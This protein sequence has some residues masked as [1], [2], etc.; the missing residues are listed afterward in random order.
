MPGGRQKRRK[1]EGFQRARAG[2]RGARVNT[3]RTGRQGGG[4]GAQTNALGVMLRGC[5]HF[6]KKKTANFET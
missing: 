1:K 5:T 3:K 4:L 2:P 6:E